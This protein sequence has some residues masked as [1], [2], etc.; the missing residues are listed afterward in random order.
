VSHGQPVDFGEKVR[1][2]EGTAEEIASAVPSPS[3]DLAARLRHRVRPR[4]NGALGAQGPE[5]LQEP[6][7]GEKLRLRVSDRP[8]HHHRA[9]DERRPRLEPG[10]QHPRVLRPA[11]AGGGI[12]CSSRRSTGSSS[13]AGRSAPISPSARAS[14]PTERPSSSGESRGERATSSGWTSPP[15]R[16]R[17]LTNDDPYDASPAISPDGKWLYWSAADGSRM[18]IFRMLVSDPSKRERITDGEGNDEDVSSLPTGS[19]S[20]FSSSR[21]GGIYNVFSLEPRDRG[22]P[23]VD[24]RFV[25][26]LSATGRLRAG[27]RAAALHGVFPPELRCLG[28]EASGAVQGRRRRQPGGGGRPADSAVP[29]KWVPEVEVPIDPAEVRPYG[30]GSF[31]VENADISVGITDDQRFYS[32]AYISWSDLLGNRR[33]GFIFDSLS[34]STNYNLSTTT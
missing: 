31:F 1:L 17:N 15:G 14:P 25:R 29:A 32:R 13:A 12:S 3:G 4:R 7:G 23:S 16:R 6:L 9:A 28:R 22:D 33:A 10:R 21:S 11:R 19:A 30:R 8:V 18:K 24:R 34:S 26:G 2:Q 5:G 27:R 20:S